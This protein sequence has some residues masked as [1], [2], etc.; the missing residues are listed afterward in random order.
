MPS[1]SVEE[2]AVVR[3]RQCC[4]IDAR[5]RSPLIPAPFAPYVCGG[6]CALHSHKSLRLCHARDGR[7]LWQ[8]HV[9]IAV[10]SNCGAL[11][12]SAVFS[13]DA[14]MASIGGRQPQGADASGFVTCE[15]VTSCDGP[16][17]RIFAKS[18]IDPQGLGRL[19][20]AFPWHGRSAQRGS[21]LCRRKSPGQ[22][23]GRH[24]WA[25]CCDPSLPPTG[26]RRDE[27]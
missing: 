21:G 15:G 12:C 17:P 23:S 11:A 27:R 8:M 6:R 1:N 20:R 14:P 7:A 19:R 10:R 2:D 16:S 3:R 5:R 24:D 4:L 26:E 13:D 18:L 9:A 25:R 22:P